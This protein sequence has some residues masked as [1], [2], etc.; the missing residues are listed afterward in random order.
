MIFLTGIFPSG[1]PIVQAECKLLTYAANERGRKC[2]PARGRGGGG[3]PADLAHRAGGRLRHIRRRQEGQHRL[4]ESG[5]RTNQGICP[6]GDHRQALFDLLYRRRPG[7]R[8]TEH[9]P[10]AR[11]DARP[12][13]GGGLARA[14]GRQLLLGVGRRHRSARSVRGVSGIREDHAGSDRAARGGGGRPRRGGGAGRSTPGRARRAGDAAIARSARPHPSEYQRRGDGPIGRAQVHLRQ[15]GGGAPVWIRLRRRIPGGLPRGDFRQV[16][17]PARRRDAVP[18]R[19][20]AR[21]ARAAGPALERRRAIP[22]QAHRRRAVVVRVRRPRPRSKWK[23]GPLG[24]CLSGV[25]RPAPER[26]GLAVPGRC[27]RRAGGVAEL[28]K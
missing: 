3:R 25:H 17:D 26:G 7:R 15:R 5:G 2:S 21:A 22:G 13:S 9:H 16:R 6:R 11:P 23:R 12:I 14:Q 8:Q 20:A 24:Q 4:M 1:L 28:S 10:H 27:E 19:R 18:A